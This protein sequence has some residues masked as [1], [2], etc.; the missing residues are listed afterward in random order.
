MTGW[1]ARFNGTEVGSV[2]ADP[3]LG[4]GNFAP[5]GCSPALTAAQPLPGGVR[6]VQDDAFGQPRGA[7][8]ASGAVLPGTALQWPRPLP[9]LQT[10]PQDG[11]APAPSPQYL[12]YEWPFVGSWDTY[13]PR[14]W[15]VDPQRGV[16]APSQSG[17]DS[18]PLA[19]PRYAMTRTNIGDTVYLRGGRGSHR[20]G[21]AVYTC[22]LTIETYPGDPRAVIAAPTNDSSIG[23]AVYLEQWGNVWE[24]PVD[25]TLRNL[26]ISG[27]Y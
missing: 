11:R 19:T 2:E 27:G 22:N 15:V 14:V 9:V 23:N 10:P 25:V 20:G 12:W 4:A 7:A 26:E 17:N 16:D 21:F 8:A 13:V 6:A 1:Q 18:F 24:V 3:Q 5:L